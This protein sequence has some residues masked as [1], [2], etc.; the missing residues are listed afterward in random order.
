MIYMTGKQYLAL[1]QLKTLNELAFQKYSDLGYSHR[2]RILPKMDSINGNLVADEIIWQNL[3]DKDDWYEIWQTKVAVNLTRF[4][5]ESN[6][7]LLQFQNIRF[8]KWSETNA[9]K[10]E[11]QMVELD[12]IIEKLRL[13]YQIPVLLRSHYD[14][15]SR[16]L[17]FIFPRMREGWKIESISFAKA[18]KQSKILETM[19]A[20]PFEQHT[21]DD[22]KF[23]LDPGQV[24]ESMNSNTVRDTIKNINRK[25][26]NSIG[27][28][29][30]LVNIS[31]ELAWIDNLH[32]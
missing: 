1:W 15:D 22:L 17:H 26:V 27:K 31:K 7:S 5:T 18:P 10:L 19:Y 8:G 21:F 29:E 16:Q 25:I 12:K 13:K 11:K 28:N 24:D 23:H 9:N 20:A 2:E 4:G 6:R 14:K 32:L 30:G 3:V